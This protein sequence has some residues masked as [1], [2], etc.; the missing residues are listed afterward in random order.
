MRPGGP[1]RRARVAK[2]FG[3]C[4]AP[5]GDDYW[6][7]AGKIDLSRRASA[8]AA[9]KAAADLAFV[10]RNAPRVDL[11]AKLFGERLGACLA[12][13]DG[14]EVLAVRLGWNRPGDNQ[15]EDIPVARE[16]WFRLMWLSNRDFC[17]L[18]DRCLLA[19]L[20]R[21][22]VIL[23]GMSNNTGMR[24]DLTGT[25]ALIGYEPLDDVTRTG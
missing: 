5:T 12:S 1:G 2:P 24:W 9:P 25:R 4:G 20:D 19:S 11:A 14:L 10:G 7:L 15:P 3:R 6:S 17:H 13:S 8:R 16:E 18:M 21:P 22:F 23:H